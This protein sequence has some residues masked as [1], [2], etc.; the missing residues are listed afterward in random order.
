MSLPIEA[1]KVDRESPEVR[2]EVLDQVRGELWRRGNL[3]HLCLPN[4]QTQI[5][6]RAH[7]QMK[8]F[9]GVPEPLVLLCHRQLGKSHLSIQLCIERAIRQPGAKIVFGMET[10]EH[11]HEIWN[12]KVGTVIADMPEEISY[13]TRKK[14]VFIRKRGWPKNVVSKIAL[15]G[16]DYNRGDGMR[17][18][19]VDMVV[20]DEVRNLRF[21][22]HVIRNVIT[23]MWKGAKN[24]LFLMLTTPPD[25]PDHDFTHYYRRAENSDSLVIW[26]ASKNPDFT[27]ND[28]RMLLPEYGS[29]EDIGWRRELEC[30][31]IADTTRLVIPEWADADGEFFVDEVPRP[32]HYKGY[33]TIDLG[34][35]D[36]TGVLLSLYDF[37]NRRICVLDELFVKYTRIDEIVGQ[38]VEKIEATFPEHV[39]RNIL[40]RSDA[41]PHEL[42]AINDALKKHNYW[43][44]SIGDKWDRDGAINSL[45]S[46]ITNGRVLVQNNCVVLDRTLKNATWNARR[47]DFERSKSIGH[48]DLLAAL[49]YQYRTVHW[50]DN[51]SPAAN[52]RNVSP[53]YA[54]IPDRS[55]TQNEEALLA[56][57]GKNK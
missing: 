56:M 15:R 29:K 20:L 55:R 32:E 34:Y 23:P 52:P 11:A 43:S 30:E 27:D 48:A 1:Q 54:Y 46:G 2:R 6:L 51:P 45:R 22:Q 50:E 8:R 44:Q 13:Y 4:A 12:D 24:P 9:P 35:V 28:E 26:P 19:N 40:I 33:V 36:H 3:K 37:E 31:M 21:L 14:Q 53:N 49:N 18:G 16:L 7:E 42:Q 17:G 41:K 5:Y 38:L 10:S 57:F 47:K 39:R 25:V